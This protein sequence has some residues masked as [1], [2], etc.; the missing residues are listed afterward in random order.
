MTTCSIPASFLAVLEAEF[1][2][3]LPDDYQGYRDELDALLDRLAPPVAGRALAK[4]PPAPAS[5]PPLP[6]E[7]YRFDILEAMRERRRVVVRMH[8]RELRDVLE[9]LSFHTDRLTGRRLPYLEIRVWWCLINLRLNELGRDAPGFRPNRGVRLS[10]SGYSG[11][12]TILTNDRQM[13]DLHWLWQSG[14]PVSPKP[15]HRALFD[16]E[17]FPWWLA[18]RF[19]AFVGGIHRKL[20]D[21]RLHEDDQLCLMALRSDAVKKR[22]Q[23]LMQRRDALE[24][25]LTRRAACHGSRLDPATIPEW[26]KDYIALRVGNGSPTRSMDARIRMFGETPPARYLTNRKRDLVKLKFGV[27]EALASSH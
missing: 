1:G 26:G 3:P 25:L 23:D 10:E 14:A 15:K 20:E 5:L 13:I 4:T 21:L 27:R 11:E 17:L 12:D 8:P 18:A 9:R 19:V 2:P 24:A 22:Q 16:S 6:G 7:D